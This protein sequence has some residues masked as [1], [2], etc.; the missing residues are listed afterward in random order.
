MT[1]NTCD[2]G[3]Y[4]C[5]CCCASVTGLRAGIHPDYIKSVAIDL[6]PDNTVKTISNVLAYEPLHIVSV[7][8][9]LVA[10]KMV[11]AGIKPLETNAEINGRE[12][13]PVCV[14]LFTSR[15]WNPLLDV[16]R[17]GFSRADDI[18][19]SRTYISTTSLTSFSP[20]WTGPP[21]LFGY[22]CDGGLYAEAISAQGAQF[23]VRVVVNYVE[24]LSF[25][26]AYG[27]PVETLQHYWDCGHDANDEFLEGFYT[28]TTF[29]L[30]V[31]GTP[32]GSTPGGTSGFNFT[33]PHFH[34]GTWWPSSVPSILEPGPPV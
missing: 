26:P 25:S 21:D 28:G 18:G 31:D 27:D 24:R 8:I 11:E 4:G 3:R 29:D 1:S 30:E 19:D 7:T 23:G 16:T 20:S 10:R 5:S 22:F 14:S 34:H 13:D 6:I 12:G 2:S 9:A 17:G 15:A 33:S 32:G